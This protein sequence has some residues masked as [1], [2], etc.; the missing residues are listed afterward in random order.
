MEL[1][2]TE[3]S[4]IAKKRYRI[5]ASFIDFLILWSI[6]MILGYFFGTP[7][8]GELGYGI[9]GLP[10]LFLILSAIFLWPISEAIWGQTIGKRI[11]GLKVTDINHN[12]IGMKKAFIR[13]FWGCIDCIF[14]IGLIIALNN[15]D[16]KRIGDLIAGTIVLKLSNNK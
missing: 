16:N 10:T 5:L 13:F 2:A 8:R 9:T 7:L 1:I 6:L 12:P 11:I 4:R 3:K 14:L 15:K